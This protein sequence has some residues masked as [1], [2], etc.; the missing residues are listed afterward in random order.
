LRGLFSVKHALA[1]VLAAAV[2]LIS[3]FLPA[4]LSQISDNSLLG[5]VQQE[6]GDNSPESFRY[7]LTTPERL[8]I[9][10]M[11][12]SNR[13][14]LQSDYAASLREK[15]IRT[16]ADD[17]AATFAYVENGNGP[18]QGEMSAESAMRACAA[19]LSA[20]L[21]DGLGISNFAISNPCKQTLYSAVDILEP[22]KNVSVWQIDYSASLPPAGSPY[23]LMEAYVDAET[24]KVYSFSFRAADPADF[25]PDG[26]AKAWLGRLGVTE[27]DD[28][29]QS[30]PLAEAAQQY[31]KY[32]TGGMDQEKTVFT[33]G[34]YE[35]INEYYVNCY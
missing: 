16:N 4:K 13:N 5:T 3:V 24:G 6:S 9:L 32:A 15:A 35:G 19:E 28:I 29:T 25:D 22:Q 12:L 34:Y 17:T 2:I 23:A 18:A 10:S 30:S 7:T 14:M 21:K 33:V 11:A 31:K 20:I 27:Y 8:Y 26:L 1:A